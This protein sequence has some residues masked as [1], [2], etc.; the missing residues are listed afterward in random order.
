ML[1]KFC[2]LSWV[3]KLRLTQA[4][5]TI[6]KARGHPSADTQRSL[7]HPSNLTTSS[8]LSAERRA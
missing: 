5:R 7:F 6:A 2:T 8:T 3:Y 4:W 1:R